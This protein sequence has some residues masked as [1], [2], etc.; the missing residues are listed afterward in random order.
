MSFRTNYFSQILEMV[1]KETSSGNCSELSLIFHRGDKLGHFEQFCR[2]CEHVSTFTFNSL[3]WFLKTCSKCPCSLFLWKFNDSSRSIGTKR[4][5]CT[6]I[7]KHTGNF[8]A[9]G[10]FLEYY[11]VIL[12]NFSSSWC[13][14][15]S[16]SFFFVVFIFCDMGQIVWCMKCH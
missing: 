3:T 12:A 16:F 6:T 1:M 7:C 11:E 5:I 10:F 14:M 9:C 15:L 13:Y 2:T 8:G 4:Y